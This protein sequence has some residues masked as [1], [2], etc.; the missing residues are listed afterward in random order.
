MYSN[1]ILSRCLSRLKK[2][3]DEMNHLAQQPKNN[4]IPLPIE[5]ANARMRSDM[6]KIN[7]VA[8]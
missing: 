8:K 1:V 6:D 5:S 3:Q 7:Q 4:N 2:M